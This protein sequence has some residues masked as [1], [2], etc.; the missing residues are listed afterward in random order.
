MSK[1]L[2]NFFAAIVMIGAASSCTDEFKYD[3]SQEGDLVQVTFTVSQD[4]VTSSRSGGLVHYPS[5]GEWPQISDGSKAKRLIWAVYDKDGMLLPE[6]AADYVSKSPEDAGVAGYGQVA[7]K[8]EQFPHVI[9][10]TLV[11]GIEYSIAFWAQDPDCTAFNT[12]D[13]HAVSVDYKSNG[14]NLCNDELRDAFCKVETFT[15]SSAP[16]MQRTI[17]LKRPFAQINVG[18]P[19]SEYETLRRSGIRIAKSKIHIENVATEFDVVSNSTHGEDATKRQAIDYEYNYI[20]AYYNW[21]VENDSQIPTDEQLAEGR[22]DLKTQDLKIDLDHDGAIA[23]YGAQNSDVNNPRDETYNYMLMAYILPA[24]RNDGTSTYSTTLDRVEFSLLPEKEGQSELT[25]S[26]E[27][28]P[29]QR[30]WRTNIFGRMFTSEVTLEIDLDP[31]YAGEY[32]YPDWERIFE[33]VAYDAMEE[34][35]LIS[36][37]IGLKWL[38]AATNGEWPTQEDYPKQYDTNLLLKAAKLQAWPTKGCF[39]FDGVNFKLQ[40][41]INLANVPSELLELIPNDPGNG[42]FTPIG[43][44]NETDQSSNMS[45]NNGYKFFSGNFDGCNHTIYNLK[46]PRPGDDDGRFYGMFG[47]TGNASKIKNVR[48]KDVD[49]RGHFYVGGIVGNC[50]SEPSIAGEGSYEERSVIHNCYIDGGIIEST[51]WNRYGLGSYDD[52]NGVGGIIGQLYKGGMITECFVRSVTIRG[53]RAI[54]GIIGQKTGDYGVSVSLI[55]NKVYDVTLIID[56]FQE[57]AEEKG[58]QMENEFYGRIVNGALI[59]TGNESANTKV[60]AF[61][62]YTEDGKRYTDIGATDFLSNPPLDIFPR[63]V[64]Y[65][66]I[67]RLQTSILGGPSAYKEYDGDDENWKGTP[68]TSSGR[69]GMYISGITIDGDTDNNPLTLDNHTVTA[70]DVNGAKDC[71][72]YIKNEATVKNITFHGATYAGQAICLAP[73]ADKEIIL[74][75]VLAYDATKVLTDDGN[76]SGGKLIV[77]KSNFRGYVK[78]S[79]GYDEITFTETTFDGSTKIY[80]ETVNRLES[81]GAVTLEGCTFIAPFEVKVGTGSQFNNCKAV[82]R[83][84]EGDI[85]EGKSLEITQNGKITV[86]DETGNLEFTAQ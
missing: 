33:G 67:V 23:P 50:Y 40:S 69:V 57:Y 52:A 53:Y 55:N 66:D 72:V 44:G 22:K 80:A 76:V 4:G 47:L 77:N 30:N 3:N 31:F 9:T 86:N 56:Q 58:M 60:Y 68:V 62:H 18:I 41:D 26:L 63:L 21:N 13:L 19:Q 71:V 11:R 29:V 73:A 85:V 8:I 78:L 83:G 75:N 36:N 28:V 24:D 6:I 2:V 39:N 37:G 48:L 43:F 20:P 27:N 45:V 17:I 70:S 61:T 5:E 16:S 82:V 25:Y 59:F 12:K 74:D 64:K 34:C 49:I 46:T 54:G 81:D 7:E 65:T 42:Y 38:S 14:N 1:K 35:I 15:V 32:N 10:L 79:T 84:P 51:S